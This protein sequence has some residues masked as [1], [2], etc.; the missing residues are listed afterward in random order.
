MGKFEAGS[1]PANHTVAE[2]VEFLQGD[3]VTVDE[4]DRVVQA[5]REGKGRVGIISGSGAAEVPAAEPE[6]PADPAPEPP[7]DPEP[8]VEP[9]P[10]VDE[11]PKTQTPE[12][13]VAL[14]I[15]LNRQRKAAFGGV[16]AAD[17]DN[18]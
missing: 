16:P 9:E 7:V 13:A 3:E 17:A 8:I 2:V 11:R 10:P 5:E 14:A 6:A 4:H 18:D 12:E 15:E 1:D